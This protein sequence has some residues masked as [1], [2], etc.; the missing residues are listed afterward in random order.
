MLAALKYKQNILDSFY[1]D[2]DDITIKRMND[3]IRN[4]RFKKND[5]VTSYT[6]RGEK[7]NDYRGIHIPGLNSGVSISL[8][9]VLTV[10][11]NI[12]FNDKNIIDHKD[13][14][15]TNNTRI[16]LR[17]TTQEMNCKNRTKRSDN[18][19]GYTGL[20]FHK[21]TGRYSVRRTINGKRLW[22]SHKT[23]EGAIE[24]WKEVEKLG[25]TDG[26]TKRHG[27]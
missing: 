10:L 9:W 16:N 3:D 7:G 24:I 8:P 12:E 17:V 27:Y 23:L 2:D 4:G 18:T 20:S 25:L 6:L 22:R 5:I 1:L 19:T 26:Y 13:G 14:D 11:R 21:P 15:I